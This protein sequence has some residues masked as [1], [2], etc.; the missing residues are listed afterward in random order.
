MWALFESSKTPTLES[1]GS[2]HGQEGQK[3]LPKVP[4][5]ALV[6]LKNLEAMSFK[7]WVVD[8]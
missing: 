6:P 2:R 4:T 8:G 5:A 1:P 3:L 7:V